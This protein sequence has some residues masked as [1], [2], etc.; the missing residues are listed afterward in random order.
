[1]NKTK[2]YAEIQTLL[3]EATAKTRGVN[4]EN[5]RLPGDPYNYNL[6]DIADWTCLPVYIILNKFLPV[7][8]PESTPICKAGFFGTLNLTED[9]LYPDQKFTQDSIVLLEKLLPEFFFL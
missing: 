1:M 5:R 4:T 9:A 6:W 7:I 2:G 8:Q 3:F